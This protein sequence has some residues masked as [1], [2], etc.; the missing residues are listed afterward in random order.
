MLENDGSPTLDEV[1]LYVDGT[2]EAVPGIATEINTILD[3]EV[4]I[5]VFSDTAKYFEG[6]IDDVRIYNRALSEAEVQALADM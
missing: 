2:E 4:K 3:N 6:L 1:K 5:G